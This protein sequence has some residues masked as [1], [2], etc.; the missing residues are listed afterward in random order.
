V[1][2]L[3]NK[4]QSSHDRYLYDDSA[5]KMIFSF[6]IYVIN[7]IMWA[8]KKYYSMWVHNNTMGSNIEC[9]E[10]TKWE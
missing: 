10:H 6:T 1:I 4:S 2:P 3:V 5:N 9:I 7:Y 8:Y